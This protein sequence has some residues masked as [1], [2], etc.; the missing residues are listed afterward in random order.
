M[1]KSVV[2]TIVLCCLFLTACA[3]RSVGIIGGADG[4]T[5]I[6]VNDGR[7]QSRKETVKMVNVDGDLY[8]ETGED[9]DIEGRCG[10][11]D[12]NFTKTVDGFEIPKNAGEANFRAEGYQVGMTK[13]TIEIPIDDD[14]EIFKKLDTEQDVL[15]Y[16]YC[17][18]LEGNRDSEVLV[19]ADTMD[20]TFE[21]AM[22][23]LTSS[24]S[25]TKKDIYVQPII[26]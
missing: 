13:D 6:I 19:L 4:P 1:K 25:A 10:V 21:E 9:N 26:D 12:G 7:T 23:N 15:K 2:L 16:K 11:L 8:Y 17:Y 5:D 18:I 22:N 3:G 14:C 24:D 20:I